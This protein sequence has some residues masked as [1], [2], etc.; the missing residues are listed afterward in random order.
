M[1][2]RPTLTW[3]WTTPV[4]PV[5][6]SWVLR[7]REVLLVVS[8]WPLYALGFSPVLQI[9]EARSSGLL[10]VLS[11]LV[12]GIAGRRTRVETWLGVVGVF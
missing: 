7:G 2:P 9:P 3:M 1:A 12:M 11:H 8:L 10:K 4:R 5:S 6:L